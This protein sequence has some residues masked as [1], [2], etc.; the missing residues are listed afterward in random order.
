MISDVSISHASQ[1]E[2][3]YLIDA[4]AIAIEVV[5]PASTART[6]EDK[7]Q[8]YFGHG[9]LEVWH[10]YGQ[11]IAVFSAP[12]AARVIV[13]DSLSTP[14][15]PGFALSVPDLLGEIVRQS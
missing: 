9:A 8:L 12:D 5:S 15:L 14:L 4:P 3:K 11:Y 10:F 1:R 6:L 7:M 2:E 13:R